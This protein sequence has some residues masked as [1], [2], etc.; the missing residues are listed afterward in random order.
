MFRKS[1]EV[2]HMAKRKPFPGYRFH[3]RTERAI[4][5]VRNA[6]GSRRD[7]MLPGRTFEVEAKKIDPPLPNGV[8]VAGAMEDLKVTWL[9]KNVP[10][11]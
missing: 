1:L 2:E 10:K 11:S 5:T 6:D 4:V 8:A 3:R 9:D 7:I